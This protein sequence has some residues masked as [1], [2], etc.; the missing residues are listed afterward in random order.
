MVAL[1]SVLL[2]LVTAGGGDTVL[3]DFYSDSCGPC[4]MMAPVV[5]QLAAK[6]YPVRQINVASEPGVAAQLRHFGNPLL[7]DARRWP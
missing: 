4:R 7:R 1:G 5:E 2:A 3:L 6:G